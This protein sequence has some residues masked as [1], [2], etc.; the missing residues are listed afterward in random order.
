MGNFLEKLP[1]RNI[2]DGREMAKAIIAGIHKGGGQRPLSLRKR[3]SGSQEPDL[4]TLRLRKSAGLVGASVDSVEAIKKI[5]VLPPQSH[6][7][8]WGGATAD[9]GATNDWHDET[10]PTAKPSIMGG[11][12]STN[13]IPDNDP[14]I[15]AAVAEVK[16]DPT[17]EAIKLDWKR[18]KGLA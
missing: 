8:Q 11:H 17:I 13:Q 18:A 3:A 4:A 5:L 6:N 15:S 10:K 9:T 14:R 16:G 12:N 1:A 2:N 7:G